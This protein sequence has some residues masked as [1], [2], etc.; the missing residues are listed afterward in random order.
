MIMP[1]FCIVH[2]VRTRRSTYV[3]HFYCEKVLE[4]LLMKHVSA[5]TVVPE[6]SLWPRKIKLMQ[7][8][9]LDQFIFKLISE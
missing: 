5:L 1:L 8:S 4:N 7:Y 6:S 2:S 3:V 9:A